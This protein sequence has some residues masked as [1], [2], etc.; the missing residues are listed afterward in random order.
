MAL[1]FFP[2]DI[3]GFLPHVEKFILERCTMKDWNNSSCYWPITSLCETHLY[4]LDH[5][6]GHEHPAREFS[7]EA[8]VFACGYQFLSESV[9]KQRRYSVFR[10]SRWRRI[11]YFRFRIFRIRHVFLRLC[12]EFHRNR[13]INSGDTAFFNFQDGVESSTSGFEFFEFG[14]LFCVWVSNFVIIGY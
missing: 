1:P 5:A 4:F 6:L 3:C 8:R 14:V 10:F 7:K 11:E 9:H 2:F 13:I 12:V